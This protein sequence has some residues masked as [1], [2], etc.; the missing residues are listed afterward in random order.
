MLFN[1]IEYALFVLTVFFLYWICCKTKNSQNIVLLALSIIFYSF[2][3]WRFLSLIFIS[4]TSDYHLGRKIFISE[5]KRKRKLYLIYSISINLSILFIFKYL[6]F[7]THEF[8]EL[9]YSL[10]LKTNINTL[11]IVLPVGISFYTFQTLSYTIDIYRKKTI[12]TNNFVVFSTF[13]SFFPQL[14]A[15]PIER[16]KKLI[17]QF[18]KKRAFDNKL[19]TSGLFLILWGIFKKVLIADNCAP[20]VDHIFS[21]HTN[22]TGISVLIGSFLFGCQIYCDFSGYSDIA[23][24]TARLLGIKLSTNFRS[25]YLAHNVS[26][27]WRKW[28]ISLSSWFKDYLYIPLGGS[29]KGFPIMLRNL[30]IVFLLSGLW[31]GAE[32]SFLIWGLLHATFL[33][34]HRISQKINLFRKPT[35]SFLHPLVSISLTFSL[36]TIAWIPFRAIDL[37]HSIDLFSKLFSN[38]IFSI[39]H[40]IIHHPNFSIVIPFILSLFITE[41]CYGYWIKNFKKPFSEFPYLLKWAFYYLV[42][43]SIYIYGNFGSNI[44]FIYFQF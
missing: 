26:E 24:G 44:E 11:N 4:I 13:V 29:K 22:Q 42:L 31:H 41:F 35:Q 3:D 5:E 28:H 12:P 25:P 16:A 21:P 1:S 2:W 20:I 34:L 18:E 33:I 6:G 8:Q 32:W 27:F 19:A 43:V 38:S 9:L 23:I 7:F 39:P 30:L 40:Q 36:V 10:G 14:V 17:P 15:G 37:Q